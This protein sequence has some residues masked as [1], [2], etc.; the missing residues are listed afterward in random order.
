MTTGT[1]PLA[2]L[3]YKVNYKFCKVSPVH[4]FDGEKLLQV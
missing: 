3:L 2:K 4:Q 1:L